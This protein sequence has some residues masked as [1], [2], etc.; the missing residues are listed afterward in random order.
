MTSA[1]EAVLCAH[2][3]ERRFGQLE[4]LFG[5]SCELRTGRWTSLMGPSGA[6]KS[7]LLQILGL[8]DQPTAGQILLNGADPWALTD[9]CRSQL[10]LAR[11]GLIFQRGNL[12]DH[13]SAL[14]NVALP[15]WRLTGSRSAAYEKATALLER[16]GLKERASAIA[17]VL[18]MGEAQRVAIARA[19]VNDPSV[20][21]ADEPTGSLDS[22]AAEAVLDALEEVTTEGTALL[23][24][25]H[26]A[27]V[28]ARGNTVL[29]IR[30]GKLVDSEAEAST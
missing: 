22:K 10:R 27:D 11:I 29:R 18:S 17:A 1:T 13:L 3:I 23:V 6:G 7:T 4:V 15:A 21:L 16:F 12:L 19:L 8:L 25:T 20:V 9:A 2:D 24:V 26:S 14:D 28:A 5:V 30:D